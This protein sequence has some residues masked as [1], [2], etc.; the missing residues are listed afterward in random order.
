MSGKNAR[1]NFS[2][3]TIIVRT[4]NCWQKIVGK[5]CQKRFLYSHDNHH[6]KMGGNTRETI[7]PETNELC[8]QKIV[9][10][11]SSEQ[12]AKQRFL[13]LHGYR[14]KK[15]GG[16][17]PAKQFLQKNTISPSKKCWDK[18][19]RKKCQKTFFFHTNIMPKK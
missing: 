3:K 17:K 8:E 9:R 2:R 5:K 18:N 14:D 7:F 12:S 13:Y 19:R 1:N 16:K 6:Q 4:K 15:M 11:K 10:K